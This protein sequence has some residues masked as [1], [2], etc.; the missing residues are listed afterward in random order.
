MV[1]IPRLIVMRKPA[2]CIY[3][4]KGPDQLRMNCAAVQC[5]CFHYIDSTLSLLP[6]SEISSLTILCGCTVRFVLD[7]V[8]NHEERFSHYQL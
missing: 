3:E 4:N 2:F 6:K 7:L 8:R 1:S 5:L